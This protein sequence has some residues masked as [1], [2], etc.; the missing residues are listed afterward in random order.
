MVLLADAG[1]H[2]AAGD[3]QSQICQRGKWNERMLMETVFSMLTA[4]NHVKYM[5]HQMQDYFEAH[6]GCLTAMFNL[7]TGWFGLSANDEG[8]FPISNAEFS[9]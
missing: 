2:A 7:I 4:V 5:R 3:H 1:V 6:L 8:F 9:L